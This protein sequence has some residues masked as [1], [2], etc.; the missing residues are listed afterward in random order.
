[1]KVACRGGRYHPGISEESL[2]NHWG[3]IEESLGNHRGIITLKDCLD[4][5]QGVI[6]E[7]GSR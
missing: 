7:A 1:M 5:F 3:I 4:A 2:R 6:L